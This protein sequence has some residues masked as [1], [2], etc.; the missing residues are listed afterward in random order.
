MLDLNKGLYC[1]T[2]K[3]CKLSQKQNDLKDNH[4]KVVVICW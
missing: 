1:L 4:L 2:A 3:L